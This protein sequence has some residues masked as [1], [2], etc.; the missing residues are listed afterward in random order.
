MKWNHY[1]A[2]FV[3][4]AALVFVLSSFPIHAFYTQK[5]VDLEV[6]HSTLSPGAIQVLVEQEVGKVFRE[7]HVSTTGEEDIHGDHGHN[8]G[9]ISEDH[10]EQMSTMVSTYI[11]SLASSGAL[12]GVPGPKGDQGPRGE[13]GGRGERGPRGPKGESGTDGSVKKVS[14]LATDHQGKDSEMQSAGDEGDSTQIVAVG[15][16]SIDAPTLRKEM[17]SAVRSY[18]DALVAS[19]ALTGPQGKKGDTGPAG[20][21]GTS[22][23]LNGL[24]GID[25]IQQHYIPAIIDSEG[26]TSFTATALNSESL[27]SE[28]AE[29]S[30]LATDGETSLRGAVTVALSMAGRADAPIKGLHVAE[31]SITLQ[32]TGTSTHPYARAMT[33]DAPTVT[34]EVPGQTV[35]SAATLYLGTPAVGQN[36]AI[37][38]NR[39]IDTESGAYLSGGGTWTNASSRALKEN[40]AD[41]DAGDM[42]KKVNQLKITRWN[43]KADS[44]DTTH[45][46][47]VAEEF[48]AAFG[49]GGIEGM[50]SIS[51]IDPS[52]IALL[53]IQALSQQILSIDLSW[54]RSTLASV[55]VAIEDGVMRVQKLFASSIQTE[56]FTVGSADRPHGIQLYDT[57]T[58]APFCVVVSNGALQNIAEACSSAS[59]KPEL[60]AQSAQET[61]STEQPTQEETVDPAP[62]ESPKE[63]SKAALPTQ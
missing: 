19:G 26:A 30:S 16:A 33:I 29:F 3:A 17:D 57:E 58:G 52:G 38:A 21:P 18:I 23:N 12:R 62:Q 13:K 34:G 45:I 43:Y 14:L 2:F 46:G 24:P 61:V 41:L 53:A 60:A 56:S 7:F 48:Y 59:V 37:T 31:P 42:L 54:L 32:G 27:K 5:A 8:Q 20:T 35:S 10:E 55:G 4:P 63:E 9:E 51:T 15:T 40:F 22:Q 47:P 28:E 39:I 6:A 49:V 25:G 36:A 1:S 11:D 50:R 44:S